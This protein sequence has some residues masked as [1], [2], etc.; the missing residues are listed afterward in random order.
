MQPVLL[1][2][3]YSC[4]GYQACCEVK[5]RNSWVGSAWLSLTFSR[6]LVRNP[7]IHRTI[8]W[9]YGFGPFPNLSWVKFLDTLAAWRPL[10][11]RSTN[12]QRAAAVGGGRAGGAHNCLMNKIGDPP[13]GRVRVP[14][15]FFPRGWRLVTPQIFSPFPPPESSMMNDV[16]IGIH[17]ELQSQYNVYGILYNCNA[18]RPIRRRTANRQ[19]LS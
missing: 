1:D 5:Q 18:Y 12:R 9:F 2:V 19:G 15:G 16:N 17:V 10:P 6:F 7:V 11:Q 8:L 13:A 14:R 3:P 4:A